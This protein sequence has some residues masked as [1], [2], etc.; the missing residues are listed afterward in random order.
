MK[1]DPVFL[2]SNKDQLP[3][4][5][6]GLVEKAKNYAMD[7]W[8]KSTQRS[9]QSLWNKF[10]SWCEERG[11][12]YLPTSSEIVSLYISYLAEEG[13]SFSTIDISIASIE[14]AH[15]LSDLKIKGERELY[16]MTRKG[17]RRTHKE[18]L[19]LK[20]AKA[21]RLIDL[22]IACQQFGSSVKDIRDKAIITTL[23]FSAMRRSE[24]VS[25]DREHIEISNQGAKLLLLGSKT[26]ESLEEIYIKRC[27]DEELCPVNAIENWLEILKADTGPVFRG[28]IKGGGISENRLSGHA[29]SVIMKEVFG[30]EYSGHSTRRG[31]IT[32]LSDKGVPLHQIQKISRHKSTD[33]ILRYSEVSKGYKSSSGS[34]L[35][36]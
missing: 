21:I 19:M 30:K 6:E 27:S 10:V 5:F 1:K 26:S 2:I 33:M 3:K 12:S 4:E 28:L 11:L 36:F 9:Y 7:S 24:L 22:K 8:S 29:V 23:F 14:L 15:K 25:I 34:V 16:S 13:K 18:K 35:G 17:I 31:V 32:E 20:Q